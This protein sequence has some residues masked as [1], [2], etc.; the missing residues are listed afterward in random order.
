M[1]PRRVGGSE[2]TAPLQPDDR[3]PETHQTCEDAHS[4]TR[5]RDERG[6]RGVSFCEWAPGDEGCEGGQREADIEEE[7]PPRMVVPPYGGIAQVD[8]DRNHGDG[9]CEGG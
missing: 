5:S 8:P 2:V 9:G 7:P 3:E 6:T 4:H 1:L